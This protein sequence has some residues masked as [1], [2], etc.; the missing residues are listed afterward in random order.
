M[1]NGI[2]VMDFE[3]E[4]S[5]MNV[6]PR[7]IVKRN[8]LVSLQNNT[9]QPIITRKQPK[10]P[11]QSVSIYFKSTIFIQIVTKTNIISSTVY[12]VKIITSQSMFTL[13]IQL[14]IVSE[15]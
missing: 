3:S 8:P 4:T 2:D 14:R 9:I 11:L 12:F 10:K 7:P 5:E 15:G 6:L 13:L 1:N